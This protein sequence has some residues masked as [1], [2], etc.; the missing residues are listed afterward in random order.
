MLLSQDL[1]YMSHIWN[2]VVCGAERVGMRLCMYQF[3]CSPKIH[4]LTNIL[5]RSVTFPSFFLFFSFLRA[6]NLRTRLLRTQNVLRIKPGVGQNIVVHECW[7]RVRRIWWSIASKAAE[8]SKSVRMH[9]LLLSIAVR[10]SLTS[11]SRAVSVHTHPLTQPTVIIIITGSG[12][13]AG[14]QWSTSECGSLQ[15]EKWATRKWFMF[16]VESMDLAHN[17]Y[18]KKPA[19]LRVRRASVWQFKI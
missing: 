1:F 4:E 3:V 17:D 15:N 10:R 7:S 13:G 16:R 19:F 14:L 8:R 12:N 5:W 9:I 2:V 18:K 6:Q 11:Q